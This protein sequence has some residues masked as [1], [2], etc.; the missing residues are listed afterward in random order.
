MKQTVESILM[1]V[2]SDMNV[3]FQLKGS[4][5]SY[6]DIFRKNG[7][8]PAILRRAEQLSLLALGLN[9]GVSFEE[10]PQGI[11]SVR[12]LIDGATPDAI[13]VF[14]CLDVLMTLHA[15]SLNNIIDVEELLYD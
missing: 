3:V 5:L 7:F 13:R 6:D 4:A 12:A 10:D 14:F 1:K 15:M 8:L 2:M 9:L 11:M